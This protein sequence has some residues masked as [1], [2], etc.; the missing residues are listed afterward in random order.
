MAKL[1]VGKRNNEFTDLYKAMYAAMTILMQHLL[2]E[3]ATVVMTKRYIARMFEARELMR[4]LGQ[5]DIDW[6]TFVFNQQGYKYMAKRRQQY[7]QRLG[8]ILAEE[9]MQWWD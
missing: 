5:D 1:E 8:Q 4:R 6:H 2:R 9:S 3:D 7:L